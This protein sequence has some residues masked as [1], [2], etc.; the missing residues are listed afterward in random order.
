MIGLP[1][2]M[3]D[4]PTILCLSLR[5]NKF[6]SIVNVY[7]PTL[8]TRSDDVNC[9]FYEDLKTRLMIVPQVHTLAVLG[10]C[11]VHIDIQHATRGKVLGRQGIGD[12]NSNGLLLLQVWTERDSS[13]FVADDVH[14][15]V[16]NM[17]EQRR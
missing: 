17:V 16:H 4:R 9:E 13:A 1:Q 2:D 6:T 14:R 12:C 8:N 7:T 3:S 11:N 5:R 15:V 10:E